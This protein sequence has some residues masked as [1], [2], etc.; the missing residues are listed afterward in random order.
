MYKEKAPA[1][2]LWKDER[3]LKPLYI[4]IVL[5]LI[6]SIVLLRDH[7]PNYRTIGYQGV[8][9]LS[10][11]GSASILVPVPGIAAVCAGPGLLGLFPLWVAILASVAE[12]LGELSGYMLGFSGR[13]FAENN[14]FYPRIERW[15]QHRGWIALGLASSIPNPLFDLIG[16]AAGTLKYPIWRFIAVVWAG[17]LLKSMSIAYACFYGIEGSLRFFGLD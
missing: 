14:R 9:V 16:V 8:F 2:K 1:Y 5:M 11:V 10:F 15:M 3:V 6:I 17:K 13:G 4:A 12:A 7:L